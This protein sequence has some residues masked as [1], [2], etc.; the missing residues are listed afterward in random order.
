[1][2]NYY[3]YV[4]QHDLIN[5]AQQ[6]ARF[7]QHIQVVNAQPTNIPIYLQLDHHGLALIGVSKSPVYVVDLY[8]HLRQRYLNRY[9]DLLVQALGHP[10]ANATVWDL[11]AGFGFD[12]CII[13]ACDYKVTVVEYNVVLATILHYVQLNKIIPLPNVSIYYAN[14]ILFC[15]HATIPPDIIYLDPMFQDNTGAKS[16][17]AMQIVQLLN[18]SN[19][20]NDIELWQAS[21][22]LARYKVVVKRDNKQSRIIEQPSPSYTKS[23]KTI[24]FDIYQS[25]I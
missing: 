10:T 21:Y 19:R 12:A 9:K 5:Q 17:Q 6:L 22:A 18:S 2:S 1:M 25:K 13:A 20:D 23:A 24:R 11:T 3:L 16:K 7:T 4:T 14:S 15:E 8:L